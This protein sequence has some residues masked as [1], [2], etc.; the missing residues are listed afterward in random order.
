MSS[1][2]WH[3]RHAKADALPVALRRFLRATALISCVAIACLLA[4]AAIDGSHQGVLDEAWR[5]FFDSDDAEDAV[6]GALDTPLA[7]EGFE[8]EVV[9]LGGRADV[10]VGAG[11]SVVGFSGQ[12]DAEREFAMLADELG[13]RGWTPVDS[14]RDDCGSFV[15]KDGKFTW[16]FVSCVQA[17]EATSVVVHCPMVDGE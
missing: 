5:M 2:S 15:K 14:G 6:E 11:G 4:Q 9:P 12:A 1:S 10:R 17:G 13:R 16:L 8:E 3:A 7:L